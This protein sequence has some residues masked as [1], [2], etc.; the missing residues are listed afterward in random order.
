MS[1]V[2]WLRQAD[3]LI[4]YRWKNVRSVHRAVEDGRLPSPQYPLSTKTPMWR[5]DIL[6]AHEAAQSFRNVSAVHA[7]PTPATFHAMRWARDIKR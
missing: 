7:R 5:P 4:R 6:E 2:V 1:Q 3:L